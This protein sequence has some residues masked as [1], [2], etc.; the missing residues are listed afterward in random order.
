MSPKP[1]IASGPNGSP[2]LVDG[3]FCDPAIAAGL[4]VAVGAAA[5]TGAAVG[6]VVGPVVG[7]VVGMTEGAGVKVV[8]G[9]GTGVGVDPGA[10]VNGGRVGGMGTCAPPAQAVVRNRSLLNVTVA[11]RASALP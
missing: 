1:S 11:V 7:A 4:G 10:I 5:A 3:R 6:A 2:V 9:E 8:I